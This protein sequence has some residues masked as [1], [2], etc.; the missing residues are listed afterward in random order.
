MKFFQETTEWDTPNAPN[1][2][3]YLS[4][5][6][7]KMVG[8]IKRGTTELFKFKSPIGIST[9]G[10]KFKLVDV[11]GEPDSV[12]FATTPEHTLTNVVATIAGSNGSVYSV[13][14]SGHTYS[15]TCTGFQF[16]RKCKHVEQFTTKETEH[17]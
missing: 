16:R 9:K 15:C 2:I 5:D 14:K 7:S 6:K 10:R 3:Y 17:A 11:K 12:Y 13:S 8:Y 4:D 1:H